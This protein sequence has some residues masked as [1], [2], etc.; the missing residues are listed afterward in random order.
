MVSGASSNASLLETMKRAA[1]EDDP[2][3]AAAVGEALLDA[4]LVVPALRDDNG[5]ARPA[6]FR[7][8]DGNWDFL[9]FTDGQAAGAWNADHPVWMEI[10]GREL[11]D[12]ALAAGGQ[13]LLTNPTGPLAGMMDREELAR[14]S[15]RSRRPDFDAL[16]APRHPLDPGIAMKLATVTNQVSGLEAVYP[17]EAETGPAKRHLVL[18]I[19]IDEG[20]DPDV[21]ASEAF[22]GLRQCLP[23]DQP[24]DILLLSEEQ[25]RQAAELVEPLSDHGSS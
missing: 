23:S 4:T 2:R 16:R 19:V 6:A 14:L 12:Y 10:P 17:L 5:A 7:R 18:G 15:R 25:R 20:A 22:E 21:V 3:R 24:T 8:D 13:R 1:A 11:V 9:C